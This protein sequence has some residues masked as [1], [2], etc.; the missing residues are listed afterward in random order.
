MPLTEVMKAY[1]KVHFIDQ[2]DGKALTRAQEKLASKIAKIRIKSLPDLGGASHIMLFQQA[3]DELFVEARENILKAETP[4]KAA[5]DE[6]KLKLKD[7]ASL[8]NSRLKF[9]PLYL[10]QQCDPFVQALEATVQAVTH[11]NTWLATYGAQT[12][13]LLNEAPLK[14]MTPDLQGD[15]TALQSFLIGRYQELGEIQQK[16]ARCP[17]ADLRITQLLSNAPEEYRKLRK[18]MDDYKAEANTFEFHMKLRNVMESYIR[19]KLDQNPVLA[20][21]C[22]PADTFSPKT[23]DEVL[24]GYH[25][26]WTT[27]KRRI[28]AWIDALEGEIARF[29]TGLSEADMVMNDDQ[30][31]VMP[32]EKLSAQAALPH[33]IYNPALELLRKMTQGAVQ[34]LTPQEVQRR[35]DDEGAKLGLKIVLDGVFDELAKSKKPILTDALR[36]KLTESVKTMVGNGDPELRRVQ[37]LEMLYDDLVPKFTAEVQHRNPKAAL[38]HE[39][40]NAILETMF[41]ALMSPETGIVSENGNQLSINGEEFIAQNTVGEGG[42][43][44]IVLMRS[45]NPPHKTVVLKGLNTQDTNNQQLMCHEALALLRVKKLPDHEPGKNNIIRLESLAL[46]SKGQPYLVLEKIDGGD[47]AQEHAS[48]KALAGLGV[49]P[50]MV[51]NVILAKQIKEMLNGLLLLKRQ[52]IKHFD[53]KP[54]NIMLTSDGSPKLI[55][56]GGSQISNSPQGETSGRNAATLDYANMTVL[57]TGQAYDEREDNFSLGKILGELFTDVPAQRDA[58]PVQPGGVLSQLLSFILNDAREYNVPLEGFMESPFFELAHELDPEALKGIVA[59]VK[60]YESKLPKPTMAFRQELSKVHPIGKTVMDDVHPHASMS[61]LLAAAHNIEMQLL[62]ARTSKSALRF[63]C[64]QTLQDA[65]ASEEEKQKAQATA[66][67]ASAE[68]DELNAALKQLA[69]VLAPV[70]NNPQ[71]AEVQKR[72]S[73]LCAEAMEHVEQKSPV[74][75]NRHEPGRQRLY[76]AADF[77]PLKQVASQPNIFPLLYAEL[78]EPWA[79]DAFKR[80]QWNHE[81]FLLELSRYM[82]LPPLALGRLPKRPPQDVYQDPIF[83]TLAQELQAASMRL[84]HDKAR[85]LPLI[86]TRA[87]DL[88]LHEFLDLLAS[89]IE[90]RVPQPRVSQPQDAQ[91][92]V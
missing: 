8:A 55:D 61:T 5:P 26:Y 4:H 35:V 44:S 67:E 34:T 66:H 57:A 78:N 68:F 30:S 73:K 29:P 33:F 77:A 71:A 81:K 86:S 20:P 87:P 59:A 39:T 47:M 19:N 83:L 37:L 3:V 89:C 80:Y 60:A 50:A 88:E 75:P 14:G 63:K 6:L 36:K 9:K 69:D 49:V 48:L 24:Q 54:A 28:E 40:G 7:A 82:V 76:V 85:L 17:R 31:K 32:P 12:L 23:P 45:K 15:M 53:L 58:K 11:L 72:L 16:I 10:V 92:Q 91:V 41:Q 74:Q 2:N 62:Q 65:N 18:L 51:K 46:D 21:I 27:A 70:K 38:T 90:L 13:A 42:Q 64:L 56:F 52:N 84:R 22:N 25:Q 79:K 1:L 43:G